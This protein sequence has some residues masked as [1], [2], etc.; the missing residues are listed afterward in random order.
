MISKENLVS[1]SMLTLWASQVFKCVVRSMS[2]TRIMDQILR[3]ILWYQVN[4]IILIILN[5]L[6]PDL[7]FQKM[8]LLTKSRK[9]LYNYKYEV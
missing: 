9:I 2:I 1:A 8:N 5:K 6:T 3:L 4:K 7:I